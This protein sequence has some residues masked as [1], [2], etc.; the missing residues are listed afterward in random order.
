MARAAIAVSRCFRLTNRRGY[1]RVAFHA[2][3]RSGLAQVGVMTGGT[4]RM[5]VESLGLVASRTD[6]RRGY[7][8]VTPVA[9]QT[10]AVT[11]GLPGGQFG[12]LLIVAGGAT[13]ACDF[14]RMSLVA[15][16]AL[17]VTIR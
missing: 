6:L 3:T 10:V 16:R 12:S 1:V 2:G 11:S 8:L 7:V 13:V 9:A 14:E 15:L 5:G 4:C 17:L